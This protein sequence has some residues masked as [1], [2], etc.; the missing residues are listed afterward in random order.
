MKIVSSSDWRDG[1]AFEDPVVVSTVVPGEPARCATCGPS[2]EPVE[3]TGLWVVKH[4]HPRHHGGFVRF[5]CRA[6]VPLPPA[7]PVAEREEKARAAARRPSVPRAPRSTAPEKPTAVCP[8]C[9][10]EVPASGVCGMCGE[11]IA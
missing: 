9:F 8:S 7:R 11:R 10:I 1:L 3:R 4:R 5:Y 2:S 6:H